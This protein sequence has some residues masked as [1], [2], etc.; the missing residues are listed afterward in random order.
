MS[1]QP[2]STAPRDGTPVDLWHK[3]GFRETEVWWADDCWSSCNE[4]DA[5]THWMPLP[6]HP[7]L[8]DG[9]PYLGIGWQQELA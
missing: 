9:G 8:P 5:Y 4:D 1:W 7:L 6:P 3:H 2:I